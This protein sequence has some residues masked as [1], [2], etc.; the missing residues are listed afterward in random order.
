MLSNLTKS[1]P[2][3][4]LLVKLCYQSSKLPHKRLSSMK[5]QTNF[6]SMK[7]STLRL[8]TTL[9]LRISTI[10]ET[11]MTTWMRTQKKRTQK[12]MTQKTTTKCQLMRFRKMK[13]MTSK[14]RMRM[15]NTN[16]LK[17]TSLNCERTTNINGLKQ[18]IENNDITL[19]QDLGKTTRSLLDIIQLPVM[20]KLS[21]IPL[22]VNT[23]LL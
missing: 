10:P 8:M 15:I 5:D 14:K 4:G 1:T 19:L 11:M 13:S 9:N 22:L 12:K 7:M 2:P 17:I 23:L 20:P 21:L 3:H 18:L 6:C 16:Q